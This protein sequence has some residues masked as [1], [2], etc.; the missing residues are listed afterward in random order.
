MPASP[1][2][3]AAT[4]SLLDAKAALPHKS[5]P[6]GEASLATQAND[7]AAVP[8]EAPASNIANP[9]ILSKSFFIL[10]ARRRFGG[11]VVRYG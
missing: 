1:Y 9:V 7:R 3:N 10:K 5:D 2:G 6:D 4:A 8:R 11:G